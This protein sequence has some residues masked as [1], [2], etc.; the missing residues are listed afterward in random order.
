MKNFRKFISIF[1]LFLFCFVVKASVESLFYKEDLNFKELNYFI[2]KGYVSR[3]KYL[4]LNYI[5]RKNN[6]QEEVYEAALDLA[7]GK[8]YKLIADIGCGAGYKLLNYFKEFQTFGFEVEPNLGYLKYHYPERKWYF[9]DFTLKDD[10]P[11]FDIVMCVDV[12]EHLLDPDRLL[13]WINKLDFKC[14]VVS[15][16]DR[17]LLFK[18]QHNI[19]I[20]K[21]PPVNRY[22]IREWAFSEF[23]KYIS[24]YFDI[25]EHFHTKKEWWSQVIIATKKSKI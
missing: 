22:H 13:N 9:S 19:Q 4:Q 14:L 6:A 15:T 1:F 2:K 8:S 5:N 10:F 21:G 3:K 17:D 12:I 23:N 20:Q 11:K 18:K 7:L 24:Q 25:V 16:P